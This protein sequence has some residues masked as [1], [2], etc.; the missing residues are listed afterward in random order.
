LI[1]NRFLAIDRI[2]KYS[3]K[4]LQLHGDADTIIPVQFGKKLFDACPSSSKTFLQVP[5][6]GHNEEW[7]EEFWEAVP[8]FLT[9]WKNGR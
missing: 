2:S 1:R 9:Q 6:L 3:G 7:P 4:L 5:Y 8:P